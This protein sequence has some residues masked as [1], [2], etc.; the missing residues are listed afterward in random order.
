MKI[1]CVIGPFLPVPPLMGGAVERM[2]LA[3]CEAFAQRGHD[4][5]MISRRF[6]DLAHDEV[7]NGV[8]HV[9]IKSADAPRS[10]LLYRLLDLAY[11]VR[12]CLMLPAGDVTIT[13][14]V[15]LP[16]LLPKRRAGRIYVN[17]SRY[18]K[19]QM[20]LYGRVDRLQAVS[21]AVAEAIC[22]QTP[23][24]AS[25]VRVINNPLS[26]DFA[27]AAGRGAVRGRGDDRRPEIIFLGRV[28]REKGV[29]LIVEAFA[30]L[31]KEFPAWRLSVIGPSD[32]REGGDGAGYRSELL[33]MARA[34]GDQIVFEGPIY[35]TDTLVDRLSHAEVFAY[36]SIADAGEAFGL[37]PLEAMACGC[38]TIV[39]GLACFED[40]VSHGSNGLVFDHGRDA[41]DNLVDACRQL[42]SDALIRDRLGRQAMVAAT[43]FAPANIS[44][45]FLADFEALIPGV[46][47]QGQITRTS[48]LF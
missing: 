20:G 41:V 9:R 35:E 10:S 34:A 45:Q 43:R 31:V 2:H 38:A 26:A 14:S 23:S 3:L 40:F 48:N 7:V 17:V 36:P 28:A 29:H 11:A 6:R 1:I 27:A 18:P 22:R 16:I 42:M 4:V 13:N 37:A 46:T 32:V 12:V 39:S 25:L 19:N 5:I 8:R 24:V 21:T 33:A 44:D 30:R 15:S 47:D